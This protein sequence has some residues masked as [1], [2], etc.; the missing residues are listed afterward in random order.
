MRYGALINTSRAGAFMSTTAIGL[1]NCV[2]LSCGKRTSKAYLSLLWLFDDIFFGAAL[3]VVGSRC[4]NVNDVA[5]EPHCAILIG[6]GTIHWQN[7]PPLRKSYLFFLF[8]LFLYAANCY[9]VHNLAGR[10]P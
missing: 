2:C 5:M 8:L 9:F 3:L 10:L 4:V 1:A 6:L 7:K